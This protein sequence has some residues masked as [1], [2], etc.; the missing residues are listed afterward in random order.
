V[1]VERVFA[2]LT[3]PD[4]IREWLPGCEAAHLEGPLA[5]GAVIQA[6]FGSRVAEFEVME[7]VPPTR[8][9]WS[10]R[11]QRRSSILAFR[12]DPVPGGTMVMVGE[13]E[14]APSLR[15]ALWGFLRSRRSP[16]GRVRVILQRLEAIRF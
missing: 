11:R 14:S 2:V 12:L 7:F 1:S 6:R 5:Q 15:A 16:N 9:A 4:R 10:E 8:F 13:V 3:N